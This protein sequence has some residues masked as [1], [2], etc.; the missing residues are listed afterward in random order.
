MLVASCLAPPLRR[1][2]AGVAGPSVPVLYP[3]PRDVAA[4]AATLIQHALSASK[5]EWR[6]DLGRLRPL[7]LAIQG[8]EP[9]CLS[10]LPCLAQEINFAVHPLPSRSTCWRSFIRP[11]A[12]EL[13]LCSR[14]TRCPA[15]CEMRVRLV[16]T[17]N[18]PIDAAHKGSLEVLLQ[19]LHE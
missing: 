11:A 13:E 10:L 12:C 2:V 1:T 5:D 3:P 15:S 6:V 19:L 7:K 14:P 16:A 9:G 18:A 17:I 4:D 8:P